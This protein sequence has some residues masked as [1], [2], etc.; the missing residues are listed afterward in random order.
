MIV[1]YTAKDFP[2]LQSFFCSIF[3]LSVIVIF[4][5]FSSLVSISFISVFRVFLLFYIPRT[6]VLFLFVLFQIHLIQGLKLEEAVRKVD[7]RSAW[8]TAI[9]SVAYPRIKG[10]LKTR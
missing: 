2:C 7:N 9:H 4:S 10:G 1:S 8:I 3:L 5:F 6:L